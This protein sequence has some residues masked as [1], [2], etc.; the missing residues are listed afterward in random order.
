RVDKVTA[1]AAQEPGMDSVNILFNGSRRRVVTALDIERELAPVPLRFGA[2][3]TVTLRKFGEPSPAADVAGGGEHPEQRL[4]PAPPAPM[5]AHQITVG[6]E[7]KMFVAA[8]EFVGGAFRLGVDLYAHVAGDPVIG[9]A[10][11]AQR[12]AVDSG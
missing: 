3:Q 2:D 12:P 10:R 1:S 6:R 7:M 4:L 8:R 11:P 5:A 9:P